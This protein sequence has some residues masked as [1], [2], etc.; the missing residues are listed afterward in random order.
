MQPNVITKE[1]PSKNFF[2][3]GFADENIFFRTIFFFL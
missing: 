1:K 2:I 3:D